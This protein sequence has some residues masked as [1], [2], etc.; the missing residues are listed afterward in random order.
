MDKE[1]EPFSEG[2]YSPSKVLLYMVPGQYGPSI[3]ELKAIVAQL[4]PE[5]Q[6][7]LREMVLA[8]HEKGYINGNEGLTPRQKETFLAAV[9]PAHTGP[10]D[11][12]AAMTFAEFKEK[13]EPVIAKVKF[14]YD[15]WTKGKSIFDLYGAGMN[16][17]D[18][19]EAVEK[20][21]KK[22]SKEDR[23]LLVDQLKNVSPANKIEAARVKKLI[24]LLETK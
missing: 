24:A 7:Q 6:A 20:I 12:D 11:P 13:F 10:A 23:R 15:K 2:L 8:I 16:A 1:S 19:R 14:R 4:S 18:K 5:E 3:K 17:W 9:T 21:N 22:L